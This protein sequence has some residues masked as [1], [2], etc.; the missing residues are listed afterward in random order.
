[1]KRK[2][3]D[4]IAQLIEVSDRCMTFTPKF[5]KGGKMIEQ[6]CDCRENVKKILRKMGVQTP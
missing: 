2:K 3:P 5:T 1:M 4:F 6:P